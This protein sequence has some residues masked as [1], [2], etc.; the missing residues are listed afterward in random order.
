MLVICVVAA[1]IA[2]ILVGAAVG[3]GYDPVV[4][5]EKDREWRLA[6]HSQVEVMWWDRRFRK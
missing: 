1:A 6:L 3:A 4:A 5:A 2:F